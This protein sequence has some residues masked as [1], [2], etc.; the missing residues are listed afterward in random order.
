MYLRMRYA[1]TW[2][3]KILHGT[4]LSN[5]NDV[6][7]VFHEHV[8]SFISSPS[9]LW[10]THPLSVRLSNIMYVTSD[11]QFWAHWLRRHQSMGWALTI[12]IPIT[13]FPSG[14]QL[15]VYKEEKGSFIFIGPRLR[16]YPWVS[17]DVKIQ[18][19]PPILITKNV[20]LSMRDLTH[21]RTLNG[22]WYKRRKKEL[23]IMHHSVNLMCHPFLAYLRCW[24]YTP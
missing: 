17:S 9:S 4:I 12:L 6:Q 21:L 13:Y 8:S 22:N 5:D 10:G 7:S 11:A 18:S 15:P 24:N 1:E 14:L 16:D 3:R 19:L 23:Q 20:Y 2:K